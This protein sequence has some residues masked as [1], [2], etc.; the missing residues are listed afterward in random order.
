MNSTRTS[1]GTRS[2]WQTYYRRRDAIDEALEAARRAADGRVPYSELPGVR[3]VFASE[4]DL[5]LAMHY[6]W[7][8]VLTGHVNVALDELDSGTARTEDP[9][10]AAGAAWR[11]AARERPVLRRVLDQHAPGS[12]EALRDAYSREM[13]LLA[14]AAG[15]A[16]PGEPLAQSSQIGATYRALLTA[17]PEPS[18][19]HSPV[20][21]LRRLLASA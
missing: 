8:Q 12:T 2:G 13:R 19:S 21:T 20:A 4:E 17:G 5:L 1:P 14:V 6:R 18:R 11:N 10:E 3:A 7:T 16:D 15:L 9:M